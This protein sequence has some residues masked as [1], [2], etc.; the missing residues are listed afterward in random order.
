MPVC[1]AHRNVRGCHHGRPRLNSGWHR[2]LDKLDSGMPI[3]PFG[4]ASRDLHTQG[5]SSFV[6]LAPSPHFLFHAFKV[7]SACPSSSSSSFTPSF[8][9]FLLVWRLSSFLY[10]PR[11]ILSYLIVSFVLN[12]NSAG[13]RQLYPPPPP[14]HTLSRNFLVPNRSYSLQETARPPIKLITTVAA[15]SRRAS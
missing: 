10:S 9:C 6:S 1:R 15:A 13:C 12:C 2:T 5:F 7:I 11:L 3:P 8:F 4:M 14:A